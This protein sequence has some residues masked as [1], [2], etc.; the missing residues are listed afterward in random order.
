VTSDSIN[1]TLGEFKILLKKHIHSEEVSPFLEKLMELIPLSTPLRERTL[2]EGLARAAS[3][4]KLLE[5]ARNYFPAELVFKIPDSLMKNFVQ[6]YSREKRPELVLVMDEGPLKTQFI[7]TIAPNLKS[8]DMLNLELERLERNEVVKN[9]LMENK[10]VVM[11]EFVDH[12][13]KQ[14]RSNPVYLKDLE[15]VL[16]EWLGGFSAPRATIRVVSDAA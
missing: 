11:K 13:R 3:P 8:K 12:C 1:V 16:S 10:E 14:I 4:E 5:V 9:R 2:Y 15:P 6:N 7:D